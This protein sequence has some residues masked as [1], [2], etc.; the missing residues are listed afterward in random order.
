MQIIEQVGEVSVAQ[1]VSGGL[2]NNKYNEKHSPSTS[3]VISQGLV[4][5]IAKGRARWRGMVPSPIDISTIAAAPV[6]AATSVTSV[7]VQRGAKDGLL[8]SGSSGALPSR[9]CWR[10]FLN[11]GIAAITASTRNMP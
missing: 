2:K 1:R 11:P 10:N 8:G 3:K 7:G 4:K 9:R 5:A 6:F